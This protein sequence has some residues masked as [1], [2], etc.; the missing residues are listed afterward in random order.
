[1]IFYFSGCGNTRWA[2]RKIA[3][4]QNE[5]LIFIP[6]VISGDCTFVLQDDE[7]IGFLF[8]V[9][10]WAPPEM[11]TGFIRRLKLENY[12]GQYSFNAS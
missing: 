9:Y 6:E 5:R 3:E 1:M 4:V 2:A 10:S 11:I 12:H 8:P 7:K